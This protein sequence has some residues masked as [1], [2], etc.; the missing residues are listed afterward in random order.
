MSH[1]KSLSTAILMAVTIVVVGCTPRPNTDIAMPSEPQVQGQSQVAKPPSQTGTVPQTPR[2][3]QKS[4]EDAQSLFK[5]EIEISKSKPDSRGRLYEEAVAAKRLIVQSNAPAALTLDQVRLPSEALDRENYAHFEDNPVKVVTENPV[6]TF[7][8]DVDTG[9]YANVR[10]ILASGE[11]PRRDAVRVEELINYFDYQYVAPSDPS[12]PFKVHTELAPTPWNPHTVLLQIGIKGY[13]VNRQQIPTS[14]LVFLIDVSGSMRAV[15]KLEL[16]K[17][18]MKLL[19]RQLRVQDRVSIVVYAGASG[20]VL[21]PVGGDQTAKIHHAIDRLSAGGSTNGGAGIRLAYSLARQHFVKNGINR[22][23][24]AT[25]GDFNVGTVDFE[26]LKNLVESERE[27]GVTLTTLGFGTGNYNDHLMEQ[28]ADVGNGNYAYIDTL[29]EAQKVLVEEMSATLHTIAKDVKIQIEF[30]PNVVAEY[31]LIGYENRILN[32][33]DFNNDKVDAGDIGAGHT[34][35]ALYE[36]SLV[37]SSHR[38]LDPLRY[39]DSGNAANAT[40]QDELAFLKL[41]YKQPLES[42]SKL[43]T[44]KIAHRDVK[45]EIGRASNGYRFAAAVAAFGQILRGGKYVG[46]FDYTD[47]VQL[48]R[49]ARGED[50]YGYRNEFVRIV[51]LAQT[52]QP[53][54][55][56]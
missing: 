30:N 27:S 53:N 54:Q 20:V 44:R 26:A 51:G 6:S 34:I 35:T 21:E 36:L 32:R 37:Q 42:N 28:L 39:G 12:T 3:E 48:A 49:A 38:W 46:D 19:A 45:H 17:N 50:T 15:N 31:R 11:L 33:E 16:L 13:E 24:L 18:A 40:K 5:K 9:S 29:N 14:N 22:V 47:V 1:L 2:D 10:R 4:R 52:L 56:G 25:D 23:I 55:P 43:I 41:R 8:I 7:S